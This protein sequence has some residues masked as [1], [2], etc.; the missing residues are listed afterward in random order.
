MNSRTLI[1]AFV[2]ACAVVAVP[3][4]PGV[5][6]DAAPRRLVVPSLDGVTPDDLRALV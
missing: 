5:R 4:V 3:S 2:L 6:M 1:S